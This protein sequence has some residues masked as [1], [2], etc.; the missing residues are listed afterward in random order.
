MLP[1]CSLNKSLS[2]FDPLAGLR[3]TLIEG[4]NVCDC[5]ISYSWTR[6]ESFGGMNSV[7]ESTSWEQS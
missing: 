3:N 4:S 6:E 1:M 5:F 2:V 7:V